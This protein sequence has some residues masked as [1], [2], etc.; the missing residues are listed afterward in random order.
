MGCLDLDRQSLDTMR[1]GIRM[2]FA[3][4]DEA[5][6]SYVRRLLDPLLDEIHDAIPPID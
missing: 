4:A 1:D 3:D 5:E 2:Q 6:A